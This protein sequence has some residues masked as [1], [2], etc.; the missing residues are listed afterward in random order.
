MDSS[1]PEG[2]LDVLTQETLRDFQTI[3][4]LNPSGV[5]DQQTANLIQ[6]IVRGLAGDVT[7][8][9]GSG[10]AAIND[11]IDGTN[12]GLSAYNEDVQ[13]LQI[14]LYAEGYPIPQI[15]GFF[16]RNTL[17][18]LQ[19][20]QRDHNLPV[21]TGEPGDM[22]INDETLNL[23]NGMIQEKNYLGS[24]FEL[25]DG[26][27]V[28]TGVLEGTFGPGFVGEKVFADEFK[29]GDTVLMYTFIDEHTLLVTTHESVIKEII[30]RL[31]LSDLF[32]EKPA[33]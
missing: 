7:L 23:I 11:Y 12:V 6:S 16:D 25:K 17:E 19:Q 24:G 8:Y 18:A 4:G 21:T 22:K 3:N 32:K 27:L 15:D 1:S 10:I 13:A 31:A 5:I 28:G 33:S 26:K 29:K 30:K 20:F 2:Q 9:G 14:F